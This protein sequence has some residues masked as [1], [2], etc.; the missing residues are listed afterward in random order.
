[1]AGNS[2]QLKTLRKTVENLKRYGGDI[3]M[4]KYKNMDLESEKVLQV[5]IKEVTG[6]LR[7]YDFQRLEQT[8]INAQWQAA[9]TSV[10]RLENDAKELGLICFLKP[11]EGIRI[12]ILKK[13]NREAQQSFSVAVNKKTTMLNFLSRS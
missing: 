7:G 11:F 5:Y 12:S 13:N 9:S 8:L 1:M 2:I 10:M 6:F 4:S 3:S